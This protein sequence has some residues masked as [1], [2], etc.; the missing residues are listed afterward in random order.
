MY[1]HFNW[2]TSYR[3]IGWSL[4]H[5]SSCQQEGV[6]Q[7]ENVV[8]VFYLYDVIPLSE[9]LKG[10]IARCDFCRRHVENARD[11][12]GISLADWSPKEGLASLYRKLD[13]SYPI[14]LS[15][16]SSNVRLHSLLSSVQEASSVSRMNLGPFGILGGGI[17]G[18]LVAI[19]LAMWLFENQIVQPRLDELG[20]V[21]LLSFVSLFL[22]AILG[23]LIEFLLRR[24]RGPATRIREV[25]NSY[26]FNLYLLEE[27][28]QEYSKNVQ[29]AVK[30]VCDQ[31]PRGL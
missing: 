27:L 20:F 5:C 15:N 31:V 13:L 30:T 21:F 2:K 14:G 18:V 25:Y 17:L 10:K 4:G 29:R 28:S 24:E 23:A 1:V 19:P 12:R 11:W 6:V 16:A 22:G 7:L 26:P 3:P 9:N 8:E